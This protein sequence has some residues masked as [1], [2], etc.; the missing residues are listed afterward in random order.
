MEDGVKPRQS[1]SRAQILQPLQGVEGTVTIF[2]GKNGL[3]GIEYVN[4]PPSGE[5]PMTAIGSVNDF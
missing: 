4:E 3:Q 2:M 1:G 5:E